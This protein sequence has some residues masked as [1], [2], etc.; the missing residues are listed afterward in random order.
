MQGLWKQFLSFKY[1]I[2]REGGLVHGPSP[3]AP[4]FAK[5]FLLPRIYL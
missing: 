4:I 3:P 2:S 1:D 5:V